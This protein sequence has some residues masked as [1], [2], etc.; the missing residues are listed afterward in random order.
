MRRP[1]GVIPSGTITLT[2]FRARIGTYIF[3]VEHGQSF[4]ITRKGKAVARLGPVD[5][6]TTILS[7]GTVLGEMPLTAGK[8]TP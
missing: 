3:A 7:D 1:A 6:A 8:G 5:D 2:E 4:T